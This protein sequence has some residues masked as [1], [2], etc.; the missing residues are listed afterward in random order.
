MRVAVFTTPRSGSQY[1][2]RNY[3]KLNNLFDLQKPEILNTFWYPKGDLDGREYINKQIEMYKNTDNSV[4]KVFTEEINREI[5]S[6]SQ[7]ERLNYYKNIVE[8]SD[9][10][11]YLF[12]RDTTK[13]IISSIIAE[14]T[15]QWR[16]KRD[17]HSEY[18]ISLKEFEQYSLAILRNHK[19]LIKIKDLFPG[20]V[21]C[22]ED[23]LINSTYQQF[24]HHHK[25]TDNYQ[26]NLDTIEKLY[27]Y[28]KTKH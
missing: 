1:F 17:D 2:V 9:K 22:S 28:E 20:E 7:E 26:Y 27:N 15:G 25:N 23:Y 16:P 14:R 6:V 4:C 12:R 19:N 8:A 24:P 10:I 18:P 3:K 5:P 21:Y 11:I 13:Q